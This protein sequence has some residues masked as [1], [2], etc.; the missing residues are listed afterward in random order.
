M[1]FLSQVGGRNVD[2]REAVHLENILK[3]KANNEAQSSPPRLGGGRQ[4]MRYRG[5]ANVL[6]LCAEMRLNPLCN[7]R[8]D[9]FIY[10]ALRRTQIP[11]L[12]RVQLSAI[13]MKFM[14]KVCI[15]QVHVCRRNAC[16]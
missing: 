16:L 1:A 10:C 5:L 12:L 4:S 3:T 7:I 15:M 8:E 11:E 9:M 13:L 2:L 14:E 6:V